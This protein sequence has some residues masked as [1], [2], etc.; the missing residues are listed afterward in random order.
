MN[1][2]TIVGAGTMGHSLAQVFAQGGHQVF[3][4]DISQDILIR[5]KRLIE[6]NLKTLADVG[7]F[8]LQDHSIVVEERIDYTTDLAAAVA[9]SG[10]VIEAIVEDPDAKKA[11]FSRL[12]RLS[13][14]EAILASNTSYLNIYEFVETKR[15]GKVIITHWFAPPHIVPLVEI[16]PGPLT[17]PETVT[18]VK[19]MIDDLGKQTIV[20]KKFLPGFIANRLQ[21]ALSLEVYHLLDNG[22]A[23]PED[24]D[25]AT[26]AS[27]GLRIPILGLVKRA[28]FAGLD[29]TQHAL[30]NKSYIP[31]A[32]KGRSDAIDS[33]VS[34]GRL[35]VK[36]GKGFYDYGNLPIE[37]ILRTR[38]LKLL[39][40][41]EFLHDMGE[42][43]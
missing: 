18:A 40:L 38:D 42:M 41:K 14:P 9:S 12:D 34:K 13:P 22:Y 19:K 16:V 33:M 8:D 29:M 25:R 39:K 6:S 36:T 5:A 43:D 15:P 3:L 32:V 21:A 24:I 7:L 23:T 1:N 35:G 10:L 26:K 4:N 11:L 37:E 2:V 17:S 31:P 20:L 27:F 28:D 30:R